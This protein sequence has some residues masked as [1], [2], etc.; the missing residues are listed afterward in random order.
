MRTWAEIDLAAIRRNAT[1]MRSRLEGGSLVAVVKA[2]A[3]G[4]GAARVAATLSGFADA[5]AVADPT[6]AE[7]ILAHVGGK[8]V[9]CLYPLVGTD[10]ARGVAL[11]LGLVA[12]SLDDV[13]AA[14]SAARQANA[15]ARMHVKLNTGMNRHGMCADE[16]AEAVRWCRQR[17]HLHLVGV[18][19][20]LASAEDP[21]DPFT[22]EQARSLAEFGA[23]ARVDPHVMHAANSGA[24]LNYGS[25]GCGAARVGIALYGA[26]PSSATRREVELSPALTWR[27]S[28]TRVARLSE[29]EGVSYGLTFV[30]PRD[31]TV[32]TLSVGYGDGYPYAAAGSAHV[33]INGQRASV[34]GSVCMDSA[35]CDVSAIDGAAAGGT[36]TLTGQDGGE[37][38]DA[39]DVASWSGTIP[40]EVFTR[41]GRRVRRQYINDV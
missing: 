23:E 40:Y 28:I 38:I 13:R 14:E 5:F 26:Y 11:E 17:D 18:W 8:P 9:M 20:H 30:A 6:E 19:T 33:L 41:I 34:L 15:V 1:A 7:E 27:A 10:I 2:N 39:A 25:L 12:S 29:G 35:V 21:G 31:M 4:H 3:Y 36:A 16:A 37:R 32:A 24:A 22:R